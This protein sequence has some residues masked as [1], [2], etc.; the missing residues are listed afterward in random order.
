MRTR[1]IEILRESHGEFVSGQDLAD[2]MGLSR[3]AVWK[4]MQA[5]RR[6]GY[7]IEARVNSGYR[8][9]AAPDR[10]YPSELMPRLKGMRLGTAL[11][12]HERVDSTMEAARKL[13]EQGAG[14]GTLVL[15]ETQENG[16]GRLGRAWASSYG[17][18][19]WLTLILRPRLLPA[20]IPNIT[21][22]AAVALARA[23]EKVAGLSPG[24][25]WPNDLYL[26][27]KKL[28]GIL[29]EM[30]GQADAVEYLILGAGLNVN[31]LEADFPPEVRPIATSLWL[32]T[33]KRQD[34]AELLA[35]FLTEFERCYYPW[36][37]CGDEEWLQEWR[38]RN[39]TLG[40]EVQVS[41]LKEVFQGRAV[42]LD[43]DGALVVETPDG[44]RRVVRAGDVTLSPR[45]GGST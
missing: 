34:R 44:E 28:C 41:F 25:K 18:G 7:V 39:I 19:L 21:L 36:Q 12:Y 23:V 38:Q 3:T 13:A 32:A 31:Q 16:R 27:D 14:E 9:L 29:T 20:Q 30:K 42:A 45:N 17:T 15:A 1:L 43:P 11:E 35:A 5:L 4:H 40:R 2:R 8:L 26:G 33:G 37:D 22:L 6:L 10:L 24:I